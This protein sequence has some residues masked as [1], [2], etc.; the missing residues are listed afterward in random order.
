MKV[1][2]AGSWEERDEIKNVMKKLEAAGHEVLVDWTCH[3]GTGKKKYALED[4]EGVVAS[5]I[6]IL[7]NPAVMSRG[8]FIETGIALAGGKNIY[9]I[10]KGEIGIFEALGR[11]KHF[12]FIEELLELMKR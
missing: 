2:V 9:I 12:D 4:F 1:Y 3:G 5:E 8:K 6:F 11:C 10:G 7:V